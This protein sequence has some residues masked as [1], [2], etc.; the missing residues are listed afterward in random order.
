MSLT[1]QF[2]FSCLA[3]LTSLVTSEP[4]VQQQPTA[5]PEHQVLAED[6]GTWDAEMTLWIPGLPDP[7]TSKGVEVNEL[8]DGGMWVLSKFESELFGQKFVGRGQFGYD[9][10]SK[11]Y[12]GTWID[13][14]SPHLSTMQGTYDAATKTL[15]MEVRSIGPDGKPMISKSVAKTISADKR[16]YETFEKREGDEWVKTMSVVYTRRP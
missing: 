11:K 16:T 3:S 8:L 10:I 5:L 9:P 15:T 2:L 4:P 12:V 7:V 6:V 14:M 13:T 1:A